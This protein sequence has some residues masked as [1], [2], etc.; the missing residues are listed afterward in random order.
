MESKLFCWRG[1]DLSYRSI[2]G[3]LLAYYAQIV[4][5]KWSLLVGKSAAP[6]CAAKCP[7]VL[8]ISN[9]PA[10]KTGYFG[11]VFRFLDRV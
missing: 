9:H 2:I 11:V 6:G 3:G 4:V 8:G 10:G 7:T 1:L 5:N